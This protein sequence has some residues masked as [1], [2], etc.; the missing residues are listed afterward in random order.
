M[1]TYD[2]W[3]LVVFQDMHI[4]ARQQRIGQYLYNR[5]F[6]YNPDLAN[7]ITATE[8]DPFYNDNRVPAFLEYVRSN[9]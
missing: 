5:L 8:F 7:S 3:L 9:W 6:G 1:L 2:G 4:A